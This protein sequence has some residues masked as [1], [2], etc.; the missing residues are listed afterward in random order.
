MRS[1]PETIGGREK[2]ASTYGILVEADG[3]LPDLSQS[4]EVRPGS[5]Y[6]EISLVR[7]NGLSGVVLL[8]NGNPAPNARVFLWGESTTSTHPSGVVTSMGGPSMIDNIKSIRCRGDGFFS[9][10]AETDSFGRFS[11]KAVPQAHSFYAVHERGFA[12]I[13]PENLP[14]SGNISLQ[15]WGRIEGVLMIGSKPGVN[16]PLL[17]STPGMSQRPLDL[18]VMFRT[19]TDSEGR[20]AF[21]SVPPGEYRISHRLAA[22]GARRSADAIARSGETRSI[23]IGVAGRPLTGRFVVPESDPN[24]TPKIGSANL[25]LKLPDDNMP[26]PSDAAAYRQW[27]ESEAG[28]ARS[29]AQR[30]YGLR[31]ETDG[32]FLLEARSPFRAIHWPPK[33][34]DCAVKPSGCKSACTRPKSSSMSRKNSAKF[35]RPDPLFPVTV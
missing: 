35:S 34:I 31:L 15:P 10:A 20:F 29:R 11:L 9:A 3:Y 14:D 17:L 21:A 24:V 26:S 5:R 27:M 4:V 22:G 18:R 16:Q 28:L 2:P 25:S 1:A 23:T 12:A 8:P 30:S 33:M 32:T 13:V 19:E 7:G 6:V